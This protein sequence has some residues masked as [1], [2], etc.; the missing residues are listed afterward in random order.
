MNFQDYENFRIMSFV[1]LAFRYFEVSGFRM[2]GLILRYRDSEFRDF[3][4]NP[5]ATTIASNNT[6]NNPLKAKD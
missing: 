2:S 6:K 1:I 3:V 5:C 4:V